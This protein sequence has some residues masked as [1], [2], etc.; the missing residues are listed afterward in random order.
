MAKIKVLKVISRLRVW[1]HHVAAENAKSLKFI[2]VYSWCL[3]LSIGKN[4]KDPN[5]QVNQ[6]WNVE[7][8]DW[9]LNMVEMDSF[10]S[11]KTK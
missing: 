3:L 2:K 8:T 11:L 7:T 5:V 10:P 4:G 9:H 6:E 1:N